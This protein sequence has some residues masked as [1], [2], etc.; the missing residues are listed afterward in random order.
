MQSE[1]LAEGEFNR[2]YVRARCLRAIEEDR[3]IKS[4]LYRM[5]SS[6][7]CGSEIIIAFKPLK[8]LVFKIRAIYICISSGI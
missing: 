8:S 4:G 2:Y 7:L 3:P 6:A 1:T 5:A